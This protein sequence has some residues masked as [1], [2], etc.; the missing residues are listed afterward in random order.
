M[1]SELHEYVRAENR[2]CPKPN[3]W[4]K[5]YD[6]LPG[7]YRGD[8][9]WVPPLPLI[10][11]AWWETSNLQKMDRL[12]L[13]INYAADHRGLEIVDRY[14]RSLSTDEWHHLSEG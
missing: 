11:A 14:L 5:L 13:H 6:I 9:G 7:K 4:N 8:S 10:L 3:Q 1:L 12:R 2:V